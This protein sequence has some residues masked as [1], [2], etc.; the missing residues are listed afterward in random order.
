MLDPIE[1]FLVQREL[2]V[3]ISKEAEMGEGLQEEEAGILS[4]L[5]LEASGKG[6]HPCSFSRKF[7]F[8]GGNARSEVLKLLKTTFP[9]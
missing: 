3:E 1:Y 4:Q 8:S 9:I 2:H 7:Y 5:C 6:R